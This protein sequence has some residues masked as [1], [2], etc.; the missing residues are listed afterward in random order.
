MSKE[1]LKNKKYNSNKGIT[2]V[3]LIVTVI[4]MLILVGVALNIALGDNGIVNNAKK[5]TEETRR[6]MYKEEL[7]SMV[8]GAYDFRED[9]LDVDKLKASIVKK[10]WTYSEG[11]NTSVIEIRDNQNR[12]IAYVNTV[13]GEIKDSN[14]NVDVNGENGDIEPP[15]NEDEVILS[16]TYMGDTIIEIQ[17]NDTFIL[18]GTSYPL[19][20]D[21]TNKTVTI[22]MGSNNVV[23]N[24]ELIKEN[25]EVINIVLLTENGIFYKSNEGLDFELD[26]DYVFDSLIMRFDAT[27]GTVSRVSVNSNTGNETIGDGDLNMPYCGYK[28]KYYIKGEEVAVSDDLNKVTFELKEYEKQ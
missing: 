1:S 19:T 14:T 11:S 26:G 13:T 5:A 25:G 20:I 3:A 4:V 6:A 7:F 2:L 8:F 24:Y 28:G 17:N 9:S 21:S 27:N 10:E 18:N 15:V 22:N 23:L 16:G 12:L